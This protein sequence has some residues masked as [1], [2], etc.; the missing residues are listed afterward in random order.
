MTNLRPFQQK[1]PLVFQQLQKGGYFSG[2]DTQ[3]L[4]IN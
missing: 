3:N 4:K 1:Y 2:F